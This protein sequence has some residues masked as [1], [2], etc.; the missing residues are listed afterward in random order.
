M[1]GCSY[2]P[3][4]VATL[5]TEMDSGRI[6]AANQAALEL[7]GLHPD[8]IV[9]RT[10]MEAGL[11]RDAGQRNSFLSCLEME[12]A[13]V[14]YPVT[15]YGS[16]GSPVETFVSAEFFE[17]SSGGLFLTRL[18]RDPFIGLGEAEANRDFVAF[19]FRTATKFLVDEGADLFRT[20]AQELRSLVPHSLVTVSSFDEATNIARIESYSIPDDLVPLFPLRLSVEEALE[21]ND[22]SRIRLLKGELFEIPFSD[23]LIS[24]KMVEPSVRL[25]LKGINAASFWRIGLSWNGVVY[26][27]VSLAIRDPDQIP[28]LAVVET[29]VRQAAV[30][31]QRN[32]R[33]HALARS[34][35]EKETLLREI[36]HRVKNNLQI[37]S[38]LL[39]LQSTGLVDPASITVLAEAAD[40]V[41]SM[42]LVHTM[43]YG[44]DNLATIDAADFLRT[45][46][47]QILQGGQYCSSLVSVDFSL[48]SVRLDPDQAIP[49]GLIVNELMTNAL[50]YGVNGPSG[51]RIRVSF[52]ELVGERDLEVAD[53]GGTLPPGFDPHASRTL[54]M[55]LVCNLAQQLGGK[56]TYRSGSETVFRVCF[57]V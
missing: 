54:G 38:S 34:L 46:A 57:P 23:E 33:S 55:Q 37:I 20:I 8:E 22:Y 19:L 36:H 41:H 25:A 49:V 50:K 7:F 24:A 27:L 51:G 42:S 13:V 31:L 12:G 45:L 21:M 5:L 52:K 6:L 43:L 44:T 47:L 11:W 10:T 1:S 9:G 16:G 39:K 48:Q 26:G 18:Y 3:G 30:A 14:R 17:G 29:F 40:R 4:A 28:D 2:T 56:L 35:H 32:D 53:S 15:F